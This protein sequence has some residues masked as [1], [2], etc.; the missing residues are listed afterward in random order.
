M[1]IGFLNPQGNFDSANSHITKHADF[2]GQL[3]Y[4]KQVAI[5]IAQMGHQV[6][7]LTRQIIDPEWPEFAEVIDT[8]PGIDNIRIIRLP[9]GPK[10][11]L[12]KELLWPHLVADWI[13]NILK[14]YQQQ[15]GLPD[16][17]TAH[18]GDGGLCG[19]LIEKETGVPFT[20]TAHSL[21]AQKIDQL[22]A[23]PENLTEI[24]EQFNFRYRILAE[25]LSMNRSAINITS[26]RQERF[27]QY[28]HRVYR[29]AVDVNNDNRFA[30]IPPGADLSIFGA[31]ARSENEE[32]TEEF[33][34][35][36]LVRDIAEA[37]RDLPVILASS[38]LEPKKNILGLVQAFAMSPT[39]QE[40]ANLMFFWK[41]WA[42]FTLEVI[43][44]Y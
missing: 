36:R 44:R 29:G 39:L 34:Q 32:A 23:T 25:R 7:I 18:Y 3:V 42:T 13:P 38:R 26:T 9:A 21:G 1:H 4:V 14:F 10:E 28:S 2:G 16:A 33:I 24:D 11:F 35:E 17:M 40:R 41:N 43:K 12:P 30:M 22:E 37:R 27:E 15:G 8:Y 31:K 6:D 19:V 20:F 5:A